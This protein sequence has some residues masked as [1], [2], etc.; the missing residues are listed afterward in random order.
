MSKLFTHGRGGFGHA[1]VHIHAYP[2]ILELAISKRHKCLC[3]GQIYYICPSFSLDYQTELFG[4]ILA[5]S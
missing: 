5:L 3:K 4:Q 2:P 1:F